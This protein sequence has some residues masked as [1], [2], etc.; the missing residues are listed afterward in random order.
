[1]RAAGEVVIG[2][3]EDQSGDAQPEHEELAAGGG[4]VTGRFVGVGG[5]GRWLLAGGW[6]GRHRTSIQV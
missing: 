6:V 5:V 3:D 2:P 1:M 4:L